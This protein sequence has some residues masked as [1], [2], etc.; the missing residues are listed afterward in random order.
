MTCER[1]NGSPPEDPV[2][3]GRRWR[4]ERDALR[5]AVAYAFCALTR[6]DN[7]GPDVTEAAVVQARVFLGDALVATNSARE[8]ER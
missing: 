5:E 2:L 7:L 4:A 6:E 8:G 1:C 3:S